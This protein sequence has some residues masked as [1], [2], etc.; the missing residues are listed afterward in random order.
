MLPHDRVRHAIFGRAPD[1]PPCGELTI[2]DDFVRECLG[3]AGPV[4]PEH[5]RELIDILGLD[6]VVVPLSH[7]WGSPI[8][9]DLDAALGE[10]AWWKAGTDLFVFGLIDGPFSHALKAWGFEEA[11]QR[12]IRIPGDAWAVLAAGAL[13][14]RGQ[15]RRV[16][17][18]GADGLILGDDLAHDANTYVSPRLL[19]ELG[20][21]AAL[22]SIVEEVSNVAKNPVFSERTGFFAS[23]S[24]KPA[25]FF[26]SDGNIRAILPDLVAAGFDGLHGLE[27]RAGLDLATVRQVVGPDV[28]LWGNV[29]LDWLAQPRLA[30]EIAALVR[31]LTAKAGPRF[32]LGTTGGLMTGIPIQNVVELHHAARLDRK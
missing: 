25:V 3:I 2:D 18:A 9:P 27:P 31:E 19:H 23:S 1:R 15:A 28:C 29:E 21:F 22:S 5:R 17:N 13:N 7:G 32:I 30:G 11:M 4:G 16:L 6:L 14:A 26:H 24:S 8:Q 12:F 20:Y 10:I